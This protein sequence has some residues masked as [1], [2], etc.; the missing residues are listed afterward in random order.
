MFLLRN[1]PLDLQCLRTPQGIQR[2]SWASKG[3]SSRVLETRLRMQW[4]TPSKEQQALLKELHDGHDVYCDAVA[5]AGKTTTVLW[6]AR[7]HPT[8]EI[9][10]VTY[11]RSLRDEVHEKAQ[12]FRQRNLRVFTYHSLSCAFYNSRT[13]T[14]QVLTQVVETNT[15][16]KKEIRGHF[17]VMDE[18]QDMTPL[19]YR[20]MRQVL[21]DW[22][23][24]APQLLLLGD[25]KQ[26]IYASKGADARFLTMAPRL[27]ERPRMRRM[28]MSDSFRLTRPMARI[29]NEG[30]LEGRP[31]LHA[32]KDGPPV[33]FVRGT[34]RNLAHTLI[35]WILGKLCSGQYQP[36]DFFILTHSVKHK[37]PFKLLEN[38]L[39]QHGVPCYVAQGDDQRLNSAV[40]QGKIVCTTFHQ[41]K[42]RER[43]FVLVYSFDSVVMRT[44]CRYDPLD[45][46]PPL[47]YVAATRAS[48]QLVLLESLQDPYEGGWQANATT[49]PFLF[50]R[51]LACGASLRTVGRPSKPPQQFR[52][53]WPG[54]MVKNVM[55]LLAHLPTSF[56]LWW[57]DYLLTCFVQV[58][59]PDPFALDPPSTSMGSAGPEEVSDLSGIALPVLWDAR[60][61]GKTHTVLHQELDTWTVNKPAWINP[62][63]AALSEP[64]E[65]SA[66]EFLQL[67][68]MYQA[69]LNHVHSK[70]TQ[71][72]EY[73]WLSQEMV[74][75]WTGRL[76]E[77]FP[78]P[79]RPP[80]LEVKVG[81]PMLYSNVHELR[82]RTPRMNAWQKQHIPEINVLD[83]VVMR[84]VMD[85][86][87]ADRLWEF[88]C[89]QQ[90]TPAHFLQVVVYLWMARLYPPP[91]GD[92]PLPAVYSLLNIRTGE[93]WEL[94]DVTHG[95]QV[96]EIMTRVLRAKCSRL[97]ALEDEAFVQVMCSQAQEDATRTRA[98][99]SC[100]DSWG[101]Q[102]PTPDLEDE[103]EWEEPVT[104]A[105]LVRGTPRLPQSQSLLLPLLPPRS[106]P[107]C[108][109]LNPRAKQPISQE[110]T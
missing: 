70:L 75:Q 48:H 7:Q 88:K 52:T 54:M 42:G 103:W 82:A 58:A 62:I 16:P 9:V 15:R 14:D 21:R 83:E 90:L 46:C 89:V 68:N 53:P 71:I 92:P 76:N 45:Q 41:S 100:S 17:L 4:P 5:G 23:G 2:H 101:W 34:P 86:V 65:L 104:R 13:H 78:D 51:P 87:S 107:A 93:Q 84:G 56:E 29:V 74:E 98:S 38:V 96:D 33:L 36:D 79:T 77:Q 106:P 109:L 40:M 63:L 12:R 22:S 20:F 49:L 26:A 60:R 32:L 11:N 105:S 43:P 1:Q 35:P 66:A 24:P 50:W 27:F 25:E 39:V 59:E 94:S 37:K 64:R 85:A 80:R 30:L 67:S 110:M 19:L 57:A 108:L 3:I 99:A 6:L 44:V 69:K 31:Y 97:F 28:G 61:T 72:E 8:K 55:D 91:P 81:A 102:D 18:A 47:V 95:K 10:Q 73:N